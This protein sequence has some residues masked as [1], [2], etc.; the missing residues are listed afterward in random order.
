MKDNLMSQILMC[1][2][3]IASAVWSVVAFLLKDAQRQYWR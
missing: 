1:G 3:M 2:F